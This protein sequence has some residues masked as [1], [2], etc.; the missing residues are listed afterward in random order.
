MQVKLQSK[1]Y[2]RFK[3]YQ[4][5]LLGSVLKHPDFDPLGVGIDLE[6]TL[7]NNQT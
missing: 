4:I 6:S 5:D 7:R 1:L 2:S 3:S